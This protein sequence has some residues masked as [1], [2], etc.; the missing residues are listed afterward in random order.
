MCLNA[1][2]FWTE[3]L[4][5]PF[6]SFPMLVNR[7]LGGHGQAQTPKLDVNVVQ[8]AVICIIDAIG[9]SHGKSGRI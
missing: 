4:S 5:F 1:I 8:N 3:N 7:P 2:F 9:V 6:T